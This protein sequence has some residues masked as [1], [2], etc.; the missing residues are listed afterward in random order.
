MQWFLDLSTFRRYGMAGPERL[1][2]L[3]VVGYSIVSG[4]WPAPWEFRALGQL[5]QAFIENHN[6][7]PPKKSP[8]FDGKPK[9]KGRRG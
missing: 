4:V 2:P 7:K 8:Q 5:D 9:P 6:R 3:D 1:T